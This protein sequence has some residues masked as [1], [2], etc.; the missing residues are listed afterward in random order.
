MSKREYFL[1]YSL[2]VKRLQKGQATFNEISEYLDRE[3]DLLDCNLGISKRTFQRDLSEIRDIFSMDIQYDFSQKAYYIVDGTKTEVTN[4]MLE[5]FDMFNALN[6]TDDLSQF[7]HFEK[8]KSKGAEHFYGLL[9][10]IKNHFIVAF[11][12]HKYEED[13]L[14]NREVEPLA[15]KEFKGRWYLIAHDPFDGYTKTFGLDRIHELKITRKKFEVNPDINVGDLFKDF[16]GIV[17]SSPR[18][19]VEVILS[20]D[21]FQGKYI[22][23][24]PLHSSQEIIADT[25]QETRIKLRLHITYDFVMELL[26]FGNRMRVISP[27]ELKD[28]IW[29]I[30][31]NALGQYKK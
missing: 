9:H 12:Y 15:L 21:S 28:E 7:I 20:F 8:R 4:R 6:L 10:C 31:N 11:P 5:A 22:K 17:N 25:E 1:R 30:F 18:G 13:V 26:S 14:V 29:S 19:L 23:S 24:F 27:K 2:I 16:F 3:S